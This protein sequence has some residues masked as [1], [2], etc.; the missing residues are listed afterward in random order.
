MERSGQRA[1]EVLVR[2][3]LVLVARLEVGLQ[4][5]KEFAVAFSHSGRHTAL[6]RAGIPLSTT[7]NPFFGGF[8]Q[9]KIIP[10]TWP[11]N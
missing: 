8:F 6:S 10:S 2:G 5:F 4:T 11:D 1:S 7:V 9:V 3:S